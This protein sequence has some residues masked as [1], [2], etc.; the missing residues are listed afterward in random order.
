MTKIFVL[1]RK[2][3]VVFTIVILAALIAGYWIYHSD[4]AIPVFGKS[5][6]ETRVYDMAAIE[7]TSTRADGTGTEMYQW[8]PST[9]YANKGETVELRI[10]GIHGESHPFIIE[11]MQIKEEVRKGE[12]TVI[13]FDATKKGIFKLV[14]LTHQD[15]E[16]NGP[17]VAHIV[18]N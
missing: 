11:G 14:C 15:D 7:F 16:T 9:V 13:Q 2:R 8:Y 4:Q 6:T 12:E 18:V 10:R 1:K 17:M 3:M 5:T